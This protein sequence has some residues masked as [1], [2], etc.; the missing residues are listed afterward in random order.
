MRYTWGNSVWTAGLGAA[1]LALLCSACSGSATALKAGQ[2]SAGGGNLPGHGGPQTADMQQTLYGTLPPAADFS[3]LPATFS[4]G[5]TA[6]ITTRSAAEADGRVRIDITA[7]HAQGLRALCVDLNY[8]PALWHSAGVQATGALAYDDTGDQA[9]LLQITGEPQPGHIEHGEAL[10]PADSANGLSGNA[11]LA[12]LWLAPGPAKAGSTATPANLPVPE[13][14]VYDPTNQQ[15][16][17]AYDLAGD[18]DQDGEV[19]VADIVPLAKYFKQSSPPDDPGLLGFE[20]Q[21][22]QSVVD[23]DRNGEIGLSDL[24]VIGKNMGAGVDGYELYGSAD[25]TQDYPGFP[26]SDGTAGVSPAFAYS[27][28]NVNYMFAA[29]ASPAEAALRVAQFD[30]QLATRPATERSAG[31]VWFTLPYARP[32]GQYLWLRATGG[33][34]YSIASNLAGRPLD[35]SPYGYP[36]DYGFSW[37]PATQQ[38][39]WQNVLRGDCNSNDAVQLSDL[40][41]LGVN[42]MH[43]GP[44][45]LATEAY[46]CDCNGDNIVDM[47]DVR[48][49]GRNLN[50][51]TIGKNYAL[52]HVPDAASVPS[53]PNAPETTLPVLA[54]FGAQQNQA[55]STVSW[56][57]TATALEPGFYYTR[58]DLGGG[59]YGPRSNAVQVP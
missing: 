20:Y 58:L 29:A 10:A 24:T 9:Q 33:T 47:R 45:G 18:Y 41:K 52:F 38:F 19:T 36:E 59:Q 22:I 49:I 11:T 8:D 12:T 1:L 56:T 28:Y 5:G 54:S 50:K 30:P 4:D 6:Q 32:D 15:V 27:Y 51:T 35:A 31:R 17:W 2:S 43:T 34:Q 46:N 23:G 44:Y 3:V 55:G 26:P 39:S 48:T 13:E 37:A 57:A 25:F 53:D 7:Q 16:T 40:T 14:V 21:T 42:I